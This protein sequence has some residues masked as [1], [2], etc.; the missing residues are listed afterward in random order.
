MTRYHCAAARSSD[1]A[2][3]LFTQALAGS[4]QCFVTHGF[5]H[6]DALELVDTIDAWLANHIGRI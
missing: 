2:H 4:R 6:E 5:V 1:E 3:A